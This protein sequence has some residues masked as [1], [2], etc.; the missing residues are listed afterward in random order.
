MNLLNQEIKMKTLI[1]SLGLF[2]TFNVFAIVNLPPGGSAIVN[3]ETVTCSGSSTSAGAV[4]CSC[5]GSWGPVGQIIVTLGLSPVDECRKLSSGSVPGSCNAVTSTTGYYKCSCNGSW[6]PVGQI[7][8]SPGISAVEEC[9]KLSSG[10][11]PG[12]CEAL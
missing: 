1:L 7:T 6:G 2:F 5:N 8:V 10:S 4:V 12:S 11:V 9:R 3:G